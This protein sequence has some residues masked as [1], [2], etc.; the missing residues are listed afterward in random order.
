MDGNKSRRNCNIISF[1]AIKKS[2][3]SEQMSNPHWVVLGRVEETMPE[4]H[5]NYCFT[6]TDVE[7]DGSISEIAMQRSRN[8]SYVTLT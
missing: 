1:K 5:N 3:K 8:S 4:R 6:K 2:K 7:K